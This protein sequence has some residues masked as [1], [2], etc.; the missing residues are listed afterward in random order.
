MKIWVLRLVVVLVTVALLNMADTRAAGLPAS[1]ETLSTST[2]PGQLLA[3]AIRVT[4]SAQPDAITS[5]GQHLKTRDFLDRLDPPDSDGNGPL[6]VDRL[7]KALAESPAPRAREVLLE[8]TRAPT[9]TRSLE[10]TDGLIEVLAQLRPAPEAAIRFW[11]AHSQPEDGFTS[12]TIAALV[13][14]GSTPALVLLAQKFSSP[15]HPDVDKIGWM[16]TEI[17][18]HRNDVALLRSC[19]RMLR[20]SLPVHLK[21]L[22]VE[23]VFDYR[24]E[25]Y[26]PH[27][28][29]EPPCRSRADAAARQVLVE[30][31]EYALRNVPLTKEQEQAVKDVLRIVAP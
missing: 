29:V 13:E 6:R 28:E 3:A 23:S 15:E 20:G 9:F 21:P 1:L 18:G 26:R 4:A 25:W 5:L 27:L 10:R 8:L 30:L 31:G 16:R 14:N 11:D 17:L 24:A 19:E 12:V 22:L 2:R 7:L